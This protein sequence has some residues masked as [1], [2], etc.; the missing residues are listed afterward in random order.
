MSRTRERNW[1]HLLRNAAT[2]A[3]LSLSL[4][5]GA[6]AQCCGD[7]NGDGEVTVHELVTS[8]NYALGGCGSDTCCGDCLGTGEVV[9]RQLFYKA[10]LRLGL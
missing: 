9:G 6:H 7:C 2:L 3:V 8:V 10:Y 1:A 5:A 4:A